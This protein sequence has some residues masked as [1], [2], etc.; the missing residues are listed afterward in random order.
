MKRILFLTLMV[1]IT[2]VFPMAV[3]NADEPKNA[4]AQTSQ[5]GD[6]EMKALLIGTWAADEGRTYTFT[7]DG[8]WLI[9]D[10]KFPNE[11]DDPRYRWDIKY[12]ELIEI[13]GPQ[14]ARPYR[15]LF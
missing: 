13:R 6:A 14:A 10:P 3:L 9:A 8:R 2:A 4:A 1:L 12:G 15:I 5:M 7:S 11:P